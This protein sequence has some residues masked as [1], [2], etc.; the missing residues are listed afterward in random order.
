MS[1]R[2]KSNSSEP[3]VCVLTQ[4]ASNLS[5]YYRKFF[6]DFETYFLTFET[7][8]KDAIDFLPGSTWSDGRNRLWEHVKGRYDYYLFVDDDLQFFCHHPHLPLQ[9]EAVLSMISNARKLPF[10]RNFPWLRFTQL[11]YQTMHSTR[12]RTLLLKRLKQYNPMVVNVR[13]LSAA[14]VDHLDVYALSRNRIV[15]PSGW[16]DA[17]F[18]LFSDVAAR[19]L[20]PYDTKISGWWSAQI[21]IYLLSHLIF[22]DR[23]LSFLELG[24][25]NEKHSLYRA[26]YNGDADCRRMMDWLGPAMD[27][28]LFLTLATEDAH[29]VNMNFAS[30]SAHRAIKIEQHSVQPTLEEMLTKLQTDFDLQHPYMHAR[31]EELIDSMKI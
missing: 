16:F 22:Q 9:T 5:L 28:N 8:N 14:S 2:S 3:R 27:K 17:Q 15:R 21:P 26:G 30:E 24:V 29:C 4:T 6:R 11:G 18:T 12:F 10:L 19:L 23:S 31:H 13:T 7:P 25:R 20:L 1:D